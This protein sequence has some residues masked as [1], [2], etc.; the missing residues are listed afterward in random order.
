MESIF[1]DSLDLNP[2]YPE[3]GKKFSVRFADLIEG[4]ASKDTIN[5]A[6][7]NKPKQIARWLI[8]RKATLYSRQP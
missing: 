7:S 8:G 5:V 4:H 6:Q 3:K 1:P 2:D